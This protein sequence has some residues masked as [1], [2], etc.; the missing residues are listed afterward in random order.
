MANPTSTGKQMQNRYIRHHR[1]ARMAAGRPPASGQA[2][3]LIGYAILA[4]AMLL[5][6][7]GAAVAH[8]YSAKG[9]T[10]AHPW[11]RATPGGATVGVAFLEM[12]AARGQG[13]RLVSASSPAAGAV[14]IHNHV[15]EGGVAKMRRVE[16]IAV[17]G[18]KSVVL[19]PSGYHLMLTDLKAPLKEGDL[20]KITLVFEKA[21][22]IDLEAT[23]EPIGA[24]GPHGFTEQPKTGS[25]GG[26]HKH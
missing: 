14:E 17:P 6:V 20:I 7:V 21:G 4:I 23:V 8:E 9:V 25:A 10:V 18:G 19:K 22:A 1:N 11:A 16:A 3:R 26:A 13:D 5:I 15:M 24:T 2:A 12:K